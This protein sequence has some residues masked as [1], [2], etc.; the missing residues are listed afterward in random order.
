LATKNN[1]LEKKSNQVKEC[2]ILCDVEGDDFARKLDCNHDFHAECIRPWLSNPNTATCPTCRAPVSAKVVEEI[3]GQV[4]KVPKTAEINTATSQEL[5]NRL[6]GVCC[7]FS[8]V[9][10]MG[11]VVTILVLF[12]RKLLG[13]LLLSSQ[14]HKNSL[15]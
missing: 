10:L 1:S 6:I 2:G 13:R 4:P 12:G 5:R 3:T 14:F 11:A 9:I 8:A 15:N 7:S